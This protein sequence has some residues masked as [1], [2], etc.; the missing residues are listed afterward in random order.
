MGLFDNLDV[1]VGANCQQIVTAETSKLGDGHNHAK[2]NYSRKSIL[3]DGRNHAG[4]GVTMSK[5]RG[6]AFSVYPRKNGVYY[7][8][9]RTDAGRGGAMSTGARTLAEAER[10]AAEWLVNGKPAKQAPQKR[11][12]V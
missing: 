11:A 7:V 5:R 1:S 4:F 6:G 2:K 10:I 12:D 9:Y 3:G 8:Q